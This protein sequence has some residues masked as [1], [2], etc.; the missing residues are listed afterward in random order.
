MKTLK[1]IVQSHLPIP[2][3]MDHGIASIDEATQ[4]K[5]KNLKPIYMAGILGGLSEVYNV[6]TEEGLPGLERAMNL[7]FSESEQYTQSIQAE[8]LRKVLEGSQS[9]PH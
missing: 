3:S 7:W 5:I 8:V 2:I 9:D 4:E 1:E 6:L